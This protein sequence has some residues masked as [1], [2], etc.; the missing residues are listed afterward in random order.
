MK[1]I[2]F[3]F[4]LI[5]F[6]SAFQKS[7]GMQVPDTEV[8]SLDGKTVK[9]NTWHNKGKPM[10][11]SFWATWCKPCKKELDAIQAGYAELKAKTGVKVV[12]VSIDDARS[13]AKVLTDIKS[14]GWEFEVYIDDAQQFKNAMQV[15]NVPH[16]FLVDGNGKIV[17]SHNSYAEGDEK[18]LFENVRKVAKGEKIGH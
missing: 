13:A 9:T 15:N 5:I 7:E 4:I 12:A 3:F 16:T 2:L 8:K 1:N 11:I 17:W 18:V 10:V 6:L 14:K